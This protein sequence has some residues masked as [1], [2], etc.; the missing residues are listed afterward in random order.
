MHCN[1]GRQLGK[2]G[3]RD[4][5]GEARLGS[6]IRPQERKLMNYVKAVHLSRYVNAVVRMPPLA[7]QCCDWKE[8]RDELLRLL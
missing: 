8:A 7:A 6:G 4:E 3:E 5:G 1:S 2:D